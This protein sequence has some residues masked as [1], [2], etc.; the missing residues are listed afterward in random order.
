MDIC[1]KYGHNFAPSMTCNTDPY[2]E[3][4]IACTV[5]G[6][7]DNRE[8]PLKYPADIWESQVSFEE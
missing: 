1:N 5:C 2:V 4:K 7:E 6:L 8:K 3:G